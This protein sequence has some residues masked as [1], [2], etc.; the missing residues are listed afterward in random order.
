[1]TDASELAVCFSSSSANHNFPGLCFFF[2]FVPDPTDVRAAAWLGLSNADRVEV[3][4]L[5][6]TIWLLYPPPSPSPSLPPFSHT[7]VNPIVS[8]TSHNPTF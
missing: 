5:L 4:G 1:M 6:K 2:L 3:A 7:R 8:P